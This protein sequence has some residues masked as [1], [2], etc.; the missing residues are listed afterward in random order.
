MMNMTCGRSVRVRQ[1]RKAGELT[2]LAFDAV[3]LGQVVQPD[4][5]GVALEGQCK[6]EGW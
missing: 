6:E 3:L 5:R 2:E 4:K 1:R